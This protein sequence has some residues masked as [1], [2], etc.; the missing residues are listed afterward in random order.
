MPRRRF[1]GTLLRAT[2]AVLVTA[3]LATLA[4]AIDI[5]VDEVA[6]GGPV[7]DAAPAEQFLRGPGPLG[8]I[9]VLGDSVLLGSLLTNPTLAEQLSAQGWG[10]VRMRAGEGYRTGHNGATPA[11]MDVGSWITTWRAQGW[12]PVDIVVNLGAND[13]GF[14]VR[15]DVACARASIEHLLDVIGPGHRIWWPKITRFYTYIDQQNTWNAALDQI[16]A[17]RDDVWTWDW[18]TE[19]RT[20]GYSSPD[21]THLSA[22]GYRKRSAVMAREITADLARGARTGADAALPADAG[23]PS[24]FV[25]LPPQRVLDTRAGGAVR[26]PAGS[27]VTIDMTPY[28]PLAASAVAVSVTT[29]QSDAPGFLTASPCDRPRAEVSNVNHTAG[30][31]RGAMAVVPLS[32]D[33]TLCVFTQAAGHVIVDLQGAF[34]PGDAGAGFE[35]VQP[36]QRLLDTRNTGR[37]EIQS[38]PVPAGSA[39]V[40]VNLTA[41]N[42]S[43]AGWLKAYP[44][45]E[46]PPEVSNVNYFP[47][48]TVASLAFVPVSPEGTICVQSYVPADVIV[49]ITGRF[50][51]GAGLR[52]VPVTPTRVLDTRT[53]LGGWSPIHGAGQTF[54][55]RVVPDGALAV[56][57]TVTLVS[58]LRPSV[59]KAFACG[60]EPATSSVNAIAGAVMANATT[61]GVS[62]T[63]RLC[64]A[65]LAAANT[66]VDVTGWWLA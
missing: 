38:I 22:D 31:V 3:T 30:G 44:C 47:G 50:V 18:P 40:A 15:N 13:S 49:D 35:P 58:P 65:G 62:S 32:A 17:E 41:T 8:G 54:D 16:A 2:A 12:D 56:T 26:R 43:S 21:L 10:P 64:L 45:G 5:A 19:M 24:T 11:S 9:T 60:P 42:V 28:V 23:A 51:D 20:G 57:G 53:G 59:V 25:P 36:A 63:G 55:T 39:A 48:E 66:L 46:L 7:V 34:V 61:V 37:A 52:F 14:C 33:G 27:T 1:A 29:D 6:G 4:V